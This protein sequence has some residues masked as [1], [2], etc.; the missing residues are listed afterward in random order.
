MIDIFYYADLYAMSLL[1]IL[2]TAFIVRAVRGGVRGRRI[3]GAWAYFLGTFITVALAFH[4]AENIWRIIPG[5]PVTDAVK[6]EYN[7]RFYALV[8]FGVMM[9][10]QGA[11]IMKAARTLA[12]GGETARA[13]LVRRTLIVLALVVPLIPIQV[14]AS[15]ITVFG[16]VNLAALALFRKKT[17]GDDERLLSVDALLQPKQ[18]CLKINKTA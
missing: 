4:V 8:L 2:E 11:E 6:P 18:L 17:A 15:L 3:A 10:V 14:F 9:I 1:F 5:T 7:F 12:F 16:M 13:A